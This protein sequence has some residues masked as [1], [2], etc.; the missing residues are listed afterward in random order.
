M[1]IVHCLSIGMIA[2]PAD[3]EEDF[4][5]DN[6]RDFWTTSTAIDESDS[7]PCSDEKHIKTQQDSPLTSHHATV[8]ID[9]K[10]LPS[11]RMLAAVPRAPHIA[12]VIGVLSLSILFLWPFSG[13]ASG[14]PEVNS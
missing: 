4:A 12:A 1:L 2:L 5:D 6:D 8:G 7:A 9:P 13:Q 11:N 14:I 3:E 10:V